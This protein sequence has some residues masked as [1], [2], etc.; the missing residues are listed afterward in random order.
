MSLREMVLT[1][2]FYHRHRLLC[3]KARLLE[4][5]VHQKKTLH[6]VLFTK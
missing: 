3:I 2:P 5:I 6:M 4:F 1:Y